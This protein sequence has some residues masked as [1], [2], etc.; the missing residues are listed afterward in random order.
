MPCD[1]L[2]IFFNEISPQKA[3]KKLYLIIKKH[4]TLGIKENI[5]KYHMEGESNLNSNS[6]KSCHVLFKW[7]LIRNLFKTNKMV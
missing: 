1:I 3:L 4:V 7:A 6:A 5:T 2:K